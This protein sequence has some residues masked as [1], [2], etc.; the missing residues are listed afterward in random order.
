MGPTLNMDTIRQFY[1]DGW[2]DLQN[3]DVAI[4]MHD[5]FQ[6]VSTWNDFAPGL[7]SIIIDTHH[8]VRYPFTLQR[9]GQLTTLTGGFQRRLTRSLTCWSHWDCLRLRPRNAIHE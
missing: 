9:H 5:A 6:D 8:Y 7:Q 1:Y 4:V 2:G 3:S